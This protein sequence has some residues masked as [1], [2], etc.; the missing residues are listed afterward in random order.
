[1]YP[2][3]PGHQVIG[4]VEQ[5]EGAG[6]IYRIGDRV[7]VAWIFHACGKCDYCKPGQ[8]NL[9]P[10]FLATGKGCH[11]GYAEYM[12][13]DENFVYKIPDSF[14]DAEA[15]PFFVPGRSDFAPCRFVI[16]ER[17]EPGTNRIW[18]IG[19]PGA[20]TGASISIHKNAKRFMFLPGAGL[21]GILPCIMD[22]PGREI[23]GQD[24]RLNWIALSIQP[25]YGQQW[26]RRLTA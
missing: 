20:E 11:G 3:I 6:K 16:K 22:V 26:L 24:R 23:H 14:S 21:N 9:C 18:R 25:R 4:I 7:G 19:P 1:M 2:V 12:A 17:D 13:A 10:D 8:E 15:A 5:H